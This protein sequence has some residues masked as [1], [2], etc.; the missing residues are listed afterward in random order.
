MEQ[1]HLQDQPL[2]AKL[3]LLRATLESTI[4]QGLGELFYRTQWTVLAPI[5]RGDISYRNF[6]KATI[7]PFTRNVKI[8]S[9][10]FGVVYNIALDPRHQADTVGAKTPAVIG[11]SNPLNS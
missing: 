10:A 3:P 4:G 8:G 7:L 11:L 5:F 9:G 2:D 1:D 6:D